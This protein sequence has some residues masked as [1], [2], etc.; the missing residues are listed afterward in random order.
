MNR[1][2]LILLTTFAVMA[3]VV[4]LVTFWPR[5]NGGTTLKVPGWNPGARSE[6]PD[7]DAPFD[8]IEVAQDGQSAV[9]VRGADKSWTLSPPEGSRPDKFKV[10]QILDLLRE[11]LV[12]VM[13]AS[14][15]A[16]DLKAFGLDPERKV[17]VTY[18]SAAQPP[19]V[20]EI[21]LSQKAEG[22]TG[23]GDSFVRV[24]GDAHVWRILG[25]DLRRP[26]EGGM[27]GLRD[28]KVLGFAA[29]DVTGIEIHDPT[30]PDAIDRDIRL[31]SDAVPG[32]APKAVEPAK[33]AERKWRFETPSGL[34][35]GDIGAFLTAVS[36]IYALE[37]VD[38]LPAGV[39]LGDDAFQVRLTLADGKVVGL[40]LGAP[41]DDA[42]YLAVDGTPGYAKVAKF[43]CD[44]VRKHTG[45]LRDRRLF[46]ITRDAIRAVD[47]VDGARRLAFER[48]G[49]RFKALLPAGLPLGRSLVDTFLTDIENLRAE[50][51]LPP[52]Q[53]AGLATGLATPLVTLAV[54]TADGARHVLKVGADKGSGTRYVS[55]DGRDEVATLPAWALTRI[56]KGPE[57]L[58]NKTFFDFEMGSVARIEI[59][60]PDQTVVLE[61]VAGK[62]SPEKAW[63]VVK[64]SGATDLKA[65]VV[66]SLVGTVAGFSA[67]AFV[68][69]AAA[70]KAA[71]G[72]PEMTLIA[73]L[74]NGSRHVL[75]VFPDKKDGDA[76]ATAPGEPGFKDVVMVLN[77]WQV[78]NV[79]RRMAEL[80][81]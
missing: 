28:R 49:N 79:Q 36:G 73:T 50:A 70:R 77:P 38:A 54:A 34:V 57:D 30:A 65:E 76:Y 20:L 3:A 68:G 17:T 48:D 78:K 63:R 37:F 60:H 22:A 81:K 72:K 69:D 1:K 16:D 74:E 19:R 4:L 61:R 42:A 21:G 43:V 27:K 64:P 9:L 8:R 53:R 31:A 15:R 11:D 2:S 7:E 75:K 47:L 46:A 45:D 80:V 40:R 66:G 71:T 51:F 59:V 56:R 29:T 39:T 55:I 52:S 23:E 35:A 44:Q 12:S 67:K 6:K 13:P 10:R 62:T 32:D 24:G 25:R 41:K 18:S 26:F 5:G 14:P 58:R 33:A